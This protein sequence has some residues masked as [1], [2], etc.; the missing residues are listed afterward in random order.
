VY[1]A[2]FALNEMSAA[3][4]G[5]AFAGAGATAEDFRTASVPDASRKILAFGVRYKP[6]AQSTLDFGYAH[7][8]INEASIN[9]SDLPLNGRLAGTYQNDVNILSVQFSHAF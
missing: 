3:A 1:A 8:F 5:N 6:A 4:I 7:V 2:G 9:R